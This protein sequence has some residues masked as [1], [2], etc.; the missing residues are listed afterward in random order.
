ATDSSTQTITVTINGAEDAPVIGGVVIGTVAED[1]TQT[2]SG[3]LTIADADT[4]QAFFVAQA[5]ASGTYGGFNVDSGGSW[6]YTL[7][8]TLPAVQALTLAQAVLD[9]FTVISADGATCTVTITVNG[10]DEPVVTLPGAAGDTGDTG[11]AQAAALATSGTTQGGATGSDGTAAGNAGSGGTSGEVINTDSNAGTGTGDAA[12]SSLS[13]GDGDGSSGA[14]WGGG[15]SSGGTSALS[16]FT[17]S[18]SGG[19]LTLTGTPSSATLLQPPVPVV[20][21]QGNLVFFRPPTIF[22]SNPGA[23]ANPAITLSETPLA[24]PGLLRQV[25]RDTPPAVL[26]PPATETQ[27]PE[28]AV[29][30][31]GGNLPGTPP[32]EP[33]PVIPQAPSDQQPPVGD[34]APSGS[35]PAA[36]GSPGLLPAD[37]SI[38]EETIPVPPPEP[39]A[40]DPA[41]GSMAIAAM[42]AGQRP[43]IVWDAPEK[44]AAV[45][46]RRAITVG[47]RHS[48]AA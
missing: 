22:F 34:L 21:T 39:G 20:L 18:G 33:A 5:N 3:T 19:T 47:P 45:R 23:W 10:V 26:P 41:I 27:A 40:F 35:Q 13:G 38:I 44:A 24:Q 28:T 29:P 2:A 11:A 8:N 15:S 25:V 43:R 48:R 30:T 7:D 16:D 46:A 1:G 32:G 4:G 14:A 37:G 6:S 17:P 9:V 42:V 36:P 12:G 31:T